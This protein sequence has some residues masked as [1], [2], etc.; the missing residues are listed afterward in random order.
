M[1]LPRAGSATK[2]CRLAGPVSPITASAT[3]GV[4][5]SASITGNCKFQAASGATLAF[6]AIDPSGAGAVTASGTAA[7]RCTTGV[8]PTVTKKAK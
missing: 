5:V 8:S 6:G 3:H 2:P 1:P 4:A 7:Y